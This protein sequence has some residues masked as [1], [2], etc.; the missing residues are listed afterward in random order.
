MLSV[1][2]ISKSYGEQVL[3]SSVGFN[4]GARDRIAVIGP[5]GSG[6]TTLFEIIAGN[7]APDTG[8]VTMRKDVTVGYSK[9][10]I[11][12][13]STEKLLDNVMRASHRITGLAHR[14]KLLQEALAEEDTED[15]DHDELLKELGDLQHQFEAAG[16]YDVQ[17]EAE[18]ILSG[19]GFKKGDFLRPLSEFSGGW[20]MRA[21]LAKLLVLNPDLLL[22]DEPTNHLDLES[23]IWF[24]D[25]LKSYQGAVMV[26]SHDRTFLNRVAGK[27][28][29]IENDDVLFYHGHYDD[30]MVARQKELEILETAARN[31]EKK[32]KKEMRFVEKFRYKAT[33]AAQVQSRLKR[34]EKIVRIEIPRNPRRIEFSFPRAIRSGDEVILL[35]DVHKSYNGNVVYQGLNLTL[36]RG[37]RIALVGPN[38]AGKTTLLKILAGVLPFEGGERILGHKVAT[39]YYA[40]VQLEMLNPDNTALDEMRASAPD[41]SDLELRGLL[42]AFLFSGDNVFKKVSV[43][44]GGEKSRLAIAK[45]LVS[46]ANFLLMDEP[47][48]HLDINSREILTDALEAYHGTICFI[49]H[50]RTLISQIANKIIEI[51]DGKPVVYQGSYEDYLEWKESS[52]QAQGQ[53]VTER[54]VPLKDLSLREINRQRK[55][56]EA[57]LR[58]SHS[59]D[60]TP[61]KKKLAGVEEKITSLENEVKELEK[62]FADPASYGDGAGV[63]AANKKHY[64]L[65]K[66]IELL[67]EEYEALFIEVEKKERVLEEAMKDVA[68]KFDGLK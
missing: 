21:S 34:L 24:E 29:S 8:S 55:E 49:T 12:P 7:I 54:K 3:F 26:T 37:D 10:E 64:E 19:L 4:I 66:T 32:F 62:R 63:A 65:K 5:N 51:R 6:K 43:L 11:V 60:I 20:L 13:F 58:N 22:L 16:G 27:I 15:N 1:V 44:S 41:G 38:G 45:M 9:Q 67:T 59:R 18:A 36:R 61:L 30:F 50:D 25:Y 14:I 46:P 52:Q 31:Q 17:H 40:Q 53:P 33:K 68:V 23:C 57:N 56:A 47:T 35:K 28:I 39:A 2:N 48:N 42:G